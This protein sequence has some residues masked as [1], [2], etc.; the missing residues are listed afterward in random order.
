MAPTR[1]LAQQIDEECIKLAKHA[2]LTTVCI[3]GGQSIEDQGFQL[4]KGVE[5]AIGTPGRM[6][7]LGFFYT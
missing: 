7:R 4:R 1:E 3:V 2:T 6:V 5:I